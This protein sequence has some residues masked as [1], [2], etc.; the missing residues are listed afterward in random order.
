MTKQKFLN[1]S[2]HNL[3]ECLFD[4]ISYIDYSRIKISL[5]SKSDFDLLLW[6]MSYIW[7]RFF[8]LF[9]GKKVLNF[10]KNVVASALKSYIISL[11]QNI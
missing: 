6:I 8:P 3:K 2:Q 11:L 9:M 7:A 4:N 5:L 10:L 1:L